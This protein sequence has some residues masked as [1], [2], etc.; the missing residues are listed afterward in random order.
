MGFFDGMKFRPN[1]EINAAREALNR[2]DDKAAIANYERALELAPKDHEI[3]RMLALLYGRNSIKLNRIFPLLDEAVQE[4]GKS[5]VTD[6]MNHETIYLRASAIYQT[7]DRSPDLVNQLFPKGKI[8]ALRPSLDFHSSLSIHRIRYGDLLSYM[9]SEEGRKHWKHSEEKLRKYNVVLPSPEQVSN[10]DASILLS[11]DYVYVSY[12]D[13]GANADKDDAPILAFIKEANL[14]YVDVAPWDVAWWLAID[15]VNDLVSMVKS[16]D[17][18]SMTLTLGGALESLME[19]HNSS[20]RKQDYGLYHL[21]R[22]YRD[23]PINKQYAIPQA[24]DWIEV[25]EAPPKI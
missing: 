23:K 7:L 17:L 4:W 8:S 9:W 20:G 15:T 14:P 24:G 10:E 12:L 2:G 5:L 6:S 19:N 25:A 1:M 11:I 22:I 13:I 3:P 21:N 18:K 16:Q